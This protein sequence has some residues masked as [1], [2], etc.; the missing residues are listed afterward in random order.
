MKKIWGFIFAFFS[1]FLA[2]QSTTTVKA[3]DFT[4]K[5]YDVDV[6]VLKDG[7]ADLTQRITYD[8]T[9]QF[10]G[11]YYNQDL[12]GIDGTSQPEIS[13]DDGHGE[14]KL[15]K[16]DSEANNTFKINQTK[17][18]MNMK[19]YHTVDSSRVT[20][21]YR[22]RIYGLITNYLDTAELNW[23]VIGKGWDN[24]LNN[25]KIKINLPQKNISKLQAW[26]HGPL[27]G[28]NE[29]NRKLGQVTITLDGLP[30]NN[31]VETHMIFPTAV[32]A[33]N[34]KVVNRN[35]KAEILIQEKKLAQEANAKRQQKK[36]IYWVIMTAGIVIILMIYLYQIIKL[37]KNPGQ[38]HQ[39]PMP[40]HH[41]FDEPKFL[42]SFAKVILDRSK[43]ADSLSLTAD[44]LDEVGHNRMKLEK[45]GKDYKITAL[46]KPTL[47]F[48]QYLFEKI[49]DGKSV[50]IKQIRHFARKHS[51]KLG[52]KFD[53]WAK[54]AAHGRE[55]YLDL[56]NLG[57]VNDFKNIT[58]VV[59]IILGVMLAVS[60]VLSSHLILS[61][62]MLTVLV[63]ITWVPYYF[64][65][66]RI[67]PYTDLGEI[68]VNKIRAFKRMLNDIDDIKLA[69]VGDLVLWERFLPY[70]V[71][72]GV[73]DKVVKA[74]KVNFS[75]EDINSSPILYYYL[76]ST[77]FLNSSSS[78][79][80]SAFTSA[81]SAGDSSISVSSGGFSGGS[82]GGFGGG[83]GGG[84]F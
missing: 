67:T 35:A 81:L 39:I 59:D 22:Y 56:G 51:N 72:F 5:D 30:A 29:V 48:Y 64:I 53:Q 24:E 58:I 26:A 36:I 14:N 47:T 54:S 37:H 38:K 77:S 78:G 11:V 79:F 13:F 27:S 42:P 3:D 82:S 68:T 65:R 62:V 16:S 69:Q 19:V 6:N 60:L 7:N 28:H 70:A 18:S 31:F 4:I 43:R 2:F 83:S 32:T 55:K 75:T 8:F 40:L 61:V 15:I 57:L 71:A 46:V 74:L 66:K 34:K 50:R 84:A 9:G 80:Q 12:R 20:Y 10:H 63:L 21:I 23:K 33:T 1:I 52:T 44:I 49:G 45:I 25:I 76:G 73:S 17:D 41:F